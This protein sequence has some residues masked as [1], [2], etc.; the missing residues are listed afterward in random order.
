MFRKILQS[1]VLVVLVLSLFASFQPVSATGTGLVLEFYAHPYASRAW[2]WTIDKSA[3][4]TSAT[5]SLG[6]NYLVNYTVALSA[7]PVDYNFRIEG[8]V[9]ATNNT[10]APVDITSLV[11]T[12]PAG[13]QA[14]TCT[15]PQTLAV[16]EKV[17]CY[18]DFS[19]AEITSDPF[20][21]GGTLTTSIGV[22]SGSIPVA[23]APYTILDEWHECVN[24]TDSAAGALGQVCA[25]EGQKSF[26][27]NYSK[28]FSY[29]VCGTY[30]FTNTASFVS[31]QTPSISGSDAVT[32]NF[33]VPC[34][35]GCS[36]TPGYWKTHSSYGPASY[37]STWALIGENTAFYLSGQTWYQV[38]WTQPQGNAYYILA[39][40]YIAAKLNNLNGADTSVV[41][42]DLAFAES[43]FSAKTPGTT[44]TKEQRAAVINAAT[45]LDN[46]NNGLT[47]P[48]HCTE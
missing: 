2:Q 31:T 17:E 19:Q 21:V 8:V 5:L 44:L 4:T 28:T 10:G 6:Q 13:G 18:F 26:S 37:D 34:A 32:V 42:A 43:F 15:L 25:N 38:L 12:P 9:K 22:Y 20:V 29:D 24:V 39:H 47:G 35:G 23:L 36:L 48:G 11:V 14:I 33:S 16:G 45:R 41:A 46:Y 7:A 40:A 1:L 30:D 3:D 27:F